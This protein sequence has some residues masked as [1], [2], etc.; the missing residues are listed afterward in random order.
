M[1]ENARLFASLFASLVFLAAC[2]DTTVV[3]DS[4]IPPDTD[5]GPVA[6][7][8]IT[9]TPEGCGYEVQTPDV[10]AAGMSEDTFA[11]PDEVHHIHTSWAGPSH[12]SVAINWESA[13]ETLASRVLYGLDMATVVAADAAGGEVMEQLGHFMLFT[14]VVGPRATRIHEVHVCGL[15]PSTTYYYKVG[16]PGHWSEV[17]DVTTA[18]VP[19]SVEPFSFAFTGDS[20]NNIENSWPIS[21]QRVLDAA[22]DFEVFNGDAVFLGSNQND[23]R[24]FFEASDGSFEI[25]DLFAR[26]PFMMA[27]GNHDRLATNYLAQFAFPQEVS[28]SER[29]QG[30]E[31]YSFDYGNA[32]FVMLN[33]TVDDAAVLG[34]A[35]ADWMRADLMAVDR[36]ATPWVFAVH[37]RGFYTCG[38]T[39]SP[40]TGLRAA[41]QPVFDEFAVDMVLTG[42]NH[43]YERSEPIRGLSG[44]DGVV[45]ASGADGEPTYAAGVA[46]GTVYV[47]A[48]GVGAELYGVANDC[49]TQHVGQVVRP[50]AVIEIEGRTLTY[51]AY[52]ATSGIAIDSF[53]LTK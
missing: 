35:Q 12:T 18:P 27:N 28:P 26:V 49:P 38:S 24:D 15:S 50:F 47:V 13:A 19:G 41:W 40:D 33:D 17:F 53:S 37:H 4:G 11:D 7:R 29:G 31:W 22:V 32:H 51:T 9:Y 16:G 21:Q 8:Q 52:D 25:Q 39:H 2:D 5:A 1:N 45:A 10:E 3:D 42:H 6:P 43:V 48:G 44:T 34:G 14:P 23:W 30:E 36:T 46:S 20:R